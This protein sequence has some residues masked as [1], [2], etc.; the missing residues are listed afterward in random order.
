MAAPFHFILAM[1]PNCTCRLVFSLTY[2]FKLQSK[3]R[4]LTSGIWNNTVDVLLRIIKF[5]NSLAILYNQR[6]RGLANLLS[7]LAF[8]Q[9]RM[10]HR[11]FD[12]AYCSSQL[13]VH[14]MFLRLPLDENLL[15]QG[16]LQPG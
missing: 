11:Q 15:P 5:R 16:I 2:Y 1:D 4:Q 12:N 8:D 14:L 3:F 13:V 6:Y 10:P 9:M 7:M